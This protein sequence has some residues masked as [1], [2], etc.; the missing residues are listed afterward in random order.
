MKIQS[1][2]I[3][4]GAERKGK[5]EKQRLLRAGT[6]VVVLAVALFLSLPSLRAFADDPKDN[7]KLKWKLDRISE[8]G[9]NDNQKAGETELEKVFPDLFSAQT[10]EKI[11]TKQKQDHAS[12]EELGKNVLSMNHE[13]D[14]VLKNTMASLFTQDYT[15]PVISGDESSS[16]GGSGAHPTVIAALATIGSAVVGGLFMAMRWFFN[17]G[18]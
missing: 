4:T 8:Y 5:T 11:E 14:T 12:L 7:G 2:K 18:K 16:G 9:K 13:Q 10:K 1:K 15:A 3:R 6:T 17:E